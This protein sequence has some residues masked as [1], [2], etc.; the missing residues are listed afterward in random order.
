M[1]G[2]IARIRRV[3]RLNAL[4]PACAIV[5]FVVVFMLQGWGGPSIDRAEADRRV[6]VVG[7]RVSAIPYR[8]GDWVGRDIE[9]PAA[10]LEILHSSTVISRTYSNLR[11]GQQARLAIVFCGD[12]RDMLGHHPPSCYPSSGWS[13]AQLA[14][15]PPAG[16]TLLL[17][18][19]GTDV[20][21][22][23]FRFEKPDAAGGDRQ[24]TIV[25]FFALP[26]VGMTPDPAVVRSRST[27]RAVSSRGAGQVQV[28]F[29]GF[30]ALEK[31]GEVATDLLEL[32]PSSTFE[33]LIDDQADKPGP[34]T[35]N[36]SRSASRSDEAGGE[37]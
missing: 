12:V 1:S 11:T 28:L 36:V 33:I 25:G 10:A 27:R 9:L 21:A 16:G 30:P 7:S 8:L 3:H 18:I 31:V 32:I 29:D 34:G 2:R 26:G 22:N 37:P 20:L 5:A 19:H 23:V 17:S 4:A 13:A 6:E 14:T 15:D 35:G 24:I